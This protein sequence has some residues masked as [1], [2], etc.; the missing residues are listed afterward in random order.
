V[1]VLRT[2]LS[3]L[4]AVLGLAVVIAAVVADP[5]PGVVPEILMVLTG[6]LLIEAAGWRKSNPW[7]PSTRRFD[8]LREEVEAFLPLIRRLNSASIRARKTGNPRDI[9]AAAMV[10]DAMHASVERMKEAA[11]YVHP[12]P[13]SLRLIRGSDPDDE[14]TEPH[15]PGQAGWTGDGN[16][17]G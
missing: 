13:P 9:Q 5:S 4:L 15:L 6:L 2:A 8:D 17:R 11:G 3:L 12:S 7:L 1:R 10:A 16:D 14:V